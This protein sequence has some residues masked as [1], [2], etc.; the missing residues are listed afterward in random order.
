VSHQ[1]HVL[2]ALA[3][4]IVTF[5]VSAQEPAKLEAK[6]APKAELNRLYRRTVDKDGLVALAEVPPPYEK[7]VT[8]SDRSTGFTTRERKDHVTVKLY[9]P[10]LPESERVQ[11]QV[12]TVVIEPWLLRNAD[13]A[14]VNAKMPQ[15]A[16]F[17]LLVEIR[18]TGDTHKTYYKGLTATSCTDQRG[19]HY[20]WRG[21]VT[22]LT[23]ARKGGDRIDGQ[24]VRDTYSFE[25]LVKDSGDILV[26]LTTKKVQHHR[27][28]EEEREPWKNTIRLCIP[29]D[30][31]DEAA[32]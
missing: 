5:P 9:D 3:C 23:R 25:R 21:V 12:G 10:K 24:V 22:K 15:E 27:Q 8:K 16:G 7:L 4:A 20:A 28:H 14:E 2:F 11:F 26:T 18:D 32:K 17:A 29:R 1:V 30:L 6:A 19:N 13:A 31:I